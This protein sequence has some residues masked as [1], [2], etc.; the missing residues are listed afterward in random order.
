MTYLTYHNVY[1][2]P[3][4]VVFSILVKIVG[5]RGCM[6]QSC[7]QVPPALRTYDDDRIERGA[8]VRS[9]RPADRGV[10]YR[11]TFIN[12][13]M[14]HIYTIFHH[15]RVSRFFITPVQL[16]S[17]YLCC[18]FQLPNRKVKRVKK[19]AREKLYISRETLKLKS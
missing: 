1:S 12:V 17:T 9:G 18:M 6:Y 14:W 16:P 15:K 10:G 7:L 4:S 8:H 11:N 3:F 13:R 19:R 5:G 2:I